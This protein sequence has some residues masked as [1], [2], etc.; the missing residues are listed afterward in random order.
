[1]ERLELVL[2]G[3]PRPSEFCPVSLDVD[4]APEELKGSVL[5][6]EAAGAAV[7]CQ[8]EADSAGSRVHWVVDS[9]AA[10]QRRR[11]ALVPGAEKPCGPQVTLEED[12]GRIVVRVGGSMFT[13]Y[14]FG[15]DLPRPFLYPLIGPFG[16]GVTRSYPMETV[17]GEVTDHP[18]HRS[19]WVAWGDVNGSDIWSETEGHGTITHQGFDKCETGPVFGHLVC[20]NHWLDADGK[21]LL[22]DRVELRFYN[23]PDSKRLFDMNVCFLATEGEVRFGD[24]KEGGVISVRVATSMDGDH[25]GIIQNSHGAMTEAET[26]GRRASWCDYSGPVSGHKVGLALFDHPSNVRYPTW[27]HVRDYGLMTAN[28]FGLSAFYG[29][30]AMDGSVVVPAGGGMGFSYRVCVHAGDAAEGGVMAEYLDWVFP[31]QAHIEE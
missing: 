21:K 5:M 29:D 6:D 17:A 18:H 11:Y 1:M 22:E 12:G 2:E 24:T 25:G 31:P 23:V 26:W 14:N 30:E 8:V 16:D 13:A 3:G 4:A 19:V 10:G 28:P 7:P 9:L 20:R 27:W 15:S